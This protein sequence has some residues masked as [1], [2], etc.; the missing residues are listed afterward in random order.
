VEKL[1]F[2]VKLGPLIL[3]VLTALNGCGY[4]PAYG[5]ERPEARLS[6]AAA[7]HKTPQLEVVQSVLSGVRAQLSTAGVLKPGNEHPLMLVEVLRVDELSSG[8]AALL[9]DPTSTERLPL[10]RGSAVGVLGRA[11]VVEAPGQEPSRDTG[12]IRRVEHYRNEDEI[13]PE[14]IR[15]GEA[16][17]AAA[18]QLG[19]ALARRILGEPD[20]AVEPM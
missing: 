20:T 13:A 16:L 2:P 1:L 4:V 14:V 17:H 6:V 10:A 9:P 15:H 18:R 3:P 5:G 7:P 8:I 11:W 12:D 19:K